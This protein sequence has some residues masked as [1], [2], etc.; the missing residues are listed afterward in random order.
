MKKILYFSIL[1]LV[2]FGCNS[3][4]K[5]QRNLMMG[6]FEQAIEIA[7]N[8]LQRDQTRSRSQEQMLILQDAFA[9]L[10]EREQKRIRFLEREK[11]QA[12]SVEIYN[13]YLNLDRIQNQISPLLPLYHE[14]LG[15]Q[16]NF[17]ME[18]Y[19]SEILQAQD[20][21]VNYYYKEAIALLNAED[22]FSARKAFDDLQKLE[23]IRP[24]YKDTRVLT[25][26]AYFI[27]TDF[28][29]VQVQN[30]TPFV[31]PQQLQEALTDFNTFG[32]DDKWT[33]Y[34]Q[35][36][37]AQLDY[38]YEININF[39]NFAFSP[40]QL[41]E[42]EISL[43]EQVVDGWR[44]KTDARGNYI[45]DD[46]GNKIK[47]DILVEAEGILLQSIQMKSVAVEAKVI[48]ADVKANRQLNS[49]PLVSEFVFENNYGQFQGDARVLSDE[50]RLLLKNRPVPFPSN[51][52]M[53]I[54]ASQDIKERLKT[55][56]KRNRIR[57]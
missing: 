48:Y 19:S 26:E 3:A 53:L 25:D 21:V 41:R 36:A 22:K 52:R 9:K 30:Q 45:T 44:Y 38:D 54:D 50:Q 28:V 1:C 14:G 18:D 34:H 17:Q 37:E 20:E 46:K 24:N 2:V 10:T 43:K 47:E 27:G 56:I 40:D 57:Q 13:T 8:H 29:L 32:L 16:I 5:A 35:Q 12:N 39:I 31:V 7:I 23:R 51:E 15:K 55:I 4:K 42:R 6:N 49:F 33:A 11:N